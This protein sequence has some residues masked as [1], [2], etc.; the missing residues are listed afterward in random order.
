MS[1]NLLHTYFQDH[2]SSMKHRELE[3]GRSIAGG[4]A[5]SS[6]GS[7]DLGDSRGRIKREQAYSQ[8][9]TK[10]ILVTDR[11]LVE[12]RYHFQI[13]M[14]KINTVFIQDKIKMF[15]VRTC[16]AFGSLCINWETVNEGD[17]LRERGLTELVY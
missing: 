12:S 14:H 10:S 2:E 1:T 15:N 4:G 13:Q 8:S 16:D 6:G 11:Y 3:V 7:F 17:S 9:Q 5:H